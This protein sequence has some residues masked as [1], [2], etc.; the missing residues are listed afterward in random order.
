MPHPPVAPPTLTPMPSDDERPGCY[1]VDLESAHPP[2][3]GVYDLSL[4]PPVAF[5]FKIETGPTGTV[6]YIWLVSSLKGVEL[7]YNLS[8]ST[9]LAEWSRSDD[10]PHSVCLSKYFSGHGCGE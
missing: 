3:D 8:N 9:F 1:N 10:E 5:L 6:S 4:I 7:L 2:L